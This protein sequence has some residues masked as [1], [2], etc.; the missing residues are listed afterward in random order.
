MPRKHSFSSSPGIKVA[1]DEDSV[2][3]N[4]YRE[5]ITDELITY[6]VEETG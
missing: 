1:Y 4:V 2:P 6:T 3:L 5:F